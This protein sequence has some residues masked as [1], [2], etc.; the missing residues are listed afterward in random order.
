M[1][2]ITDEM[3]RQGAANTKQYAILILKKGPNY[4]E[5]VANGRK[6]IWEHGRRNYALRAEGM[7]SIVCPITD[8]GE[9]AGIGVFNLSVEETIDVMKQDPAVQAGVL[10]FEVHPGRSFPGDTLPQ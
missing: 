8:D 9:Y 1:I 4:A 3:M 2:E 10:A 7:L 6:V 5:D